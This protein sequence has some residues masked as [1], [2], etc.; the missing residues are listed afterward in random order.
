MLEG[1]LKDR[2]VVLCDSKLCLL[3]PTTVLTKAAVVP[4]VAAAVIQ[5]ALA[6]APASRK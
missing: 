1:G 2:G 3:I 5:L 4:V 6:A